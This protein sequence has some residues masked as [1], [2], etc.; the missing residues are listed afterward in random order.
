[1][2]FYQPCIAMAILALSVFSHV[3]A[4]EPPAFPGAEG[5]GAVAVGGRGGQ[6]IEV[7]NLNDAGSGSF[8]AAC[9]ASGKRTVVFCTGGTIEVRSPISIRDPFITI[10]GQT[11]PGDGILLKANPSYDG[12][13]I[14]VMTHD[15]IIRGLRIRR[16]PTQ[17]K[18]CC[19]DGISIANS[20]SSPHSIIIDRCSISWGTDENM[21]AWYSAHDITVQWCIFSEALYNSSHEKGPH[22]KGTII[23]ADV[24]RVSYHHN[25]LVHNVERNPL[26]NNHRGPNHVINNVIYNWK[27]AGG[28][29]SKSKQGAAHV[30]LIGNTYLAGADTRKVRYEVVLSNYPLEPLVYVR[31]NIGH[32]RADGTGDQWA[33]V[34]DA[35]SGLGKKWM[36]IPASRKIQRDKPWPDSPIPVQ[37]QSS[38]EAYETVLDGAGAIAPQRDRVDERVVNDVR[39]RSGKC[40]DSPAEVGG[41]PTLDP[42]QP[43]VDTDHDGMPDPWEN[44][45][46]L[47]SNDASDRNQVDS[48]GYTRLEQYINSLIPRHSIDH[49]SVSQ[50]DFIPLDVEHSTKE[51]AERVLREQ[52]LSRDMHHDEGNAYTPRFA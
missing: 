37:T 39:N 46:G 52:I 27:Y 51:S 36:H 23:G 29:F 3:S 9:E 40:I 8:R 28:Q 4:I 17:K 47:N 38:S 13:V 10:A 30:N 43:P 42:G 16:G 7:T 5:F 18:G 33:V 19:G 50:S 11:A 45:Q 41:W 14:G 12:A 21:D 22:S 25:L 44:Q 49:S 32:H 2:S 1:M 31:D 48:D 24:R 34:G 6:V 35:S 26:F 20:K 15:V